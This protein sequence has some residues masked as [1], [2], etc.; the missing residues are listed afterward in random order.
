MVL[1][2]VKVAAASQEIFDRRIL[3]RASRLRRD[4]QDVQE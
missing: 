1:S 4:K 3:L 2:T